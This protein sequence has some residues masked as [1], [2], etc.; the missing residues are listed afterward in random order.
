MMANIN[1]QQKEVGVLLAVGLGRG[2]LT[3]VYVHESLILVL[4]ASFM[5]A[6]IGVVTAIVFTLQQTLFNQVCMWADSAAIVGAGLF[7]TCSVVCGVVADADPVWP[8]LAHHIVGCYHFCPV[9]RCCTSVSAYENL[10]YQT[11]TQRVLIETKNSPIAVCRCLLWPSCVTLCITSCTFVMHEN[12]YTHTS[13]H[14]STMSCLYLWRDHLLCLRVQLG[15][16]IH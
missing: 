9:I 16:V 10:H 13:G 7:V 2:A 4:A 5:G 12:T 15:N 3:R 6:A 1:E 14:C 11:V 8:A